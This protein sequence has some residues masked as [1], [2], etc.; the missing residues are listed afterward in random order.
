VNL[1][2]PVTDDLVIDADTTETVGAELVMPLGTKRR[3]QLLAELPWRPIRGCPGR[4][5]LDGLSE[6]PVEELAGLTSP[7]SVRTSKIAPDPVVVVQ[8]VN[9]GLIS[10]RKPDGRHLHTL[11]TPEAFERKLRQLGFEP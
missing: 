5:V 7:A 1:T 10:Y 4:L 2:V 8:L 11:A 9:G 6:R 3:E